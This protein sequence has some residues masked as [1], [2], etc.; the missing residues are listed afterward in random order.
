[1]RSLVILIL[2]FL[3]GL[4]GETSLLPLARSYSDTSSFVLILSAL[5]SLLTLFFPAIA[6][7]LTTAYKQQSISSWSQI[8]SL[9]SPCFGNRRNLGIWFAVTIAVFLLAFYSEELS[10]WIVN[11]LQGEWGN[12]IRTYSHDAEAHQRDI[13]LAQ[14]ENLFLQIFCVALVPAIAEELFMRG[15]L[16]PIL[17]RLMGNR[18]MGILLTALIFTLL[19]LSVVH[20]LGILLFALYFGYITHYTR[21][22]LPSIVVH[23]INNTITIL[24]LHFTQL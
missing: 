17:I 16:Q 23:F 13:L 15:A 5:A 8:I 6:Y 18:H 24:S 1:M 21:S 7:A 3:L 2:F 14:R 22:I 11:N 12:R 20:F 9:R 4:I 10:Q 19:H